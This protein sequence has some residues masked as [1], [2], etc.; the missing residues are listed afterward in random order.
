[1]ATSEWGGA[2]KGSGRKKG[3]INGYIY[4]PKRRKVNFTVPETLAEWLDSVSMEYRKKDIIDR[5]IALIKDE[6]ESGKSPLKTKAEIEMEKR[7][8]K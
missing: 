8:A 3:K 5:A 1:M 7:E 2:R 4:S 6:I